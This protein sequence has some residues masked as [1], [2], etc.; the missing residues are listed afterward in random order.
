MDAGATTTNAAS[1]P[2]N[3]HYSLLP[4]PTYSDS[5][6]SSANTQSLCTPENPSIHL[7]GRDIHRDANLKAANARFMTATKSSTGGDDALRS[8]HHDNIENGGLA[9]ALDFNHSEQ[10]SHSPVSQKAGHKRNLSAA[11]RHSIQTLMPANEG[12]GSPMSGNKLHQGI[13]GLDSPTLLSKDLNESALQLWDTELDFDALGS[14]SMSDFLM[15]PPRLTVSLSQQKQQQQQSPGNSFDNNDD[16]KRRRTTL[17][18]TDTPQRPMSAQ[19]VMQSTPPN[20]WTQMQAR[21][22]S[23]QSSVASSHITQTPS[24]LPTSVT[25]SSIFSS[26]GSPQVKDEVRETRHRRHSSIS[27]DCTS[28]IATLTAGLPVP[29]IVAPHS[30]DQE[31]SSIQR[32]STTPQPMD[33]SN[34]SFDYSE[35]KLEKSNKGADVWPDDVEVAFWE[36]LRLIPKLGRRKVLVHGK[37]CGRNELIADYIERKTGKTRTRKQVSSHIQV[38]KNVKKGDAE[39]QQLIAEPQTEEDFYIPAGGMMY[40]QTLASYGYGGLGGPIFAP[41]GNANLFSP[42]SNTIQSPLTPAHDGLTTPLTAGMTSA[43]NGMHIPSPNNLAPQDPKA[44]SSQS[45][46]I[47]PASFSMW[48]HCSNNDS[49]HIYTALDRKDVAQNNNS[50]PKLSMDSVRL[51]SFRFPRLAEMYHHLPCQ[52]LHIYVPLAVPRADVVLPRFDH[53]STQLSLTSQQGTN[54]TSVTTVFSHGKRVLSL[55]E[56][57]DTPRRISG[58]SGT[59][60]GTDDANP[61]PTSPRGGSTENAETTTG[62]HRFWHQAPFATDFWADF[63]SRNHP[64]SVYNTGES[65]QSFGKEPS[66]RAA[67][68]MAVSGVT[69]VQEFV[70]ASEQQG[71]SQHSAEAPMMGSHIMNES[72]NHVSP[73]SKIGNVVLVI[74]WDLECVESLGSEAGKPTVSILTAASPSPRPALLTPSPYNA[75]IPL[76]RSPSASSHNLSQSTQASPMMLHPSLASPFGNGAQHSSI[77]PHSQQS[78]AAF[79][80]VQGGKDPSQVPTLLRKRGM[81]ENKPNLTV[82]IPPAP[83]LGVHTGLATAAAQGRPTPSPTSAMTH[84]AVAWGLM[85][86]RTMQSTPVTP[87]PQMVGTPQEPPPMGGGQGDHASRENR[88]RLARAWAA[89]ALTHNQHLQGQNSALHSPLDIMFSQGSKEPGFKSQAMHAQN[90]QTGRQSL[91]PPSFGLEGN[92]NGNTATSSAL[93]ITGIGPSESLLSPVHFD[94]SNNSIGLTD[95][96]LENR[97][98]NSTSSAFETSLDPPMD[99]LSTQEWMDQLLQSVGVLTSEPNN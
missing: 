86:Q 71:V 78:Q 43:F 53:F 32:Q 73:G 75:P 90:S 62:K 95:A 50:L 29:S 1:S 46:P 98:G 77:S 28:E 20:S 10:A 30:P 47:L 4:S 87:F 42:Y 23:I 34:S 35:N 76:S 17:A 51:S 7:Q 26:G 67:L 36:A 63:L 96:S 82:S 97:E 92:Q 65:A 2:Q 61:N 64:V 66:E 9:A 3:T 80:Q 41:D 19:T 13:N 38:L 91:A 93:G 99:H 74:A 16:L 48:V 39:F 81:V 55:V 83:Q 54:L 14:V 85:Q 37:P 60:S 45:C 31:E 44:A 59:S 88:D 8:V 58:R 49:R 15:S 56:P 69:I 25:N 52:F 57:L 70:V 11:R 89:A 68:G 6:Q 40:A 18:V 24:S 84:N 72:G 79:G 94:G 12:T 33:S 22:A 21:A 5:S 27:G